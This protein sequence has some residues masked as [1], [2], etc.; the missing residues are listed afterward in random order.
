MIEDAGCA[1]MQH[2]APA[3]SYP[4]LSKAEGAPRARNS[5]SLLKIVVS[6]TPKRCAISATVNPSA[7]A[8]RMLASS[9][10]V[11]VRRRYAHMRRTRR[12]S[13]NLYDDAFSR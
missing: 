12:Q 3:L 10:S 8:A 4:Q 13:Y 5:A 6:V 2:Q 7:R 11:H 9:F 1:L